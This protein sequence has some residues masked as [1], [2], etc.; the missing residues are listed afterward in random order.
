MFVAITVKFFVSYI[1]SLWRD[2][3]QLSETEA[4]QALKYAYPSEKRWSYI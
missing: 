2:V 1:Q 4:Y 3:V